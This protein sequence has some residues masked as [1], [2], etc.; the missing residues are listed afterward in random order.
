MPTII[1]NSLN[2]TNKKVLDKMNKMDFMYVSREAKNQ[3]DHG[4]EFIELNAV[5]LL[6][7]EL[8][9]LKEAVN[10]I[11]GIG[12]KVFIRSNKVSTL[13]EIAKFANKEIILGDIEFD[14]KKIDPVIDLLNDGKSKIIARI[15]ENG[16]GTPA[17]PEKSLYIAQKYVDY[18]LDMGVRRDNIVLDPVIMPLEGDCKNGR[19]FLNTLELFKIDFPRVKTVAHMFDLSEG[20]PKRQLISSHFVA[21]AIEKG[22]DYISVNA[23]DK[24]IIESIITTLSIIG[25]DKNMQGYISYCRNSREAKK[26]DEKNLKEA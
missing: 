23:L 1:G 24:S 17:S 8:N 11:E 16:S 13:L 19:K 18:L 6:N 21:L 7:N 20:L 12:G 25:K 3:L 2:S 26:E 9:F 22:L 4:A 15:K 10:V 5:S 14:K